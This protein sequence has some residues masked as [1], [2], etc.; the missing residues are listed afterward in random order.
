MTDILPWTDSHRMVEAWSEQRLP[1]EPKGNMLD[2]R[3]RLR[4]ELRTLP[5]DGGPALIAEY[6][7]E[8]REVCDVENVLFYNVGLRPFS[9][10]GV[11]QLA[12]S[13]VQGPPRQ[14]AGC[15]GARHYVSYRRA[16]A[17]STPDWGE[18]AATFTSA[19]LKAG[20]LGKPWSAWYAL[21]RGHTHVAHMIDDK[22]GFR[23]RVV[24][25]CPHPDSTSLFS[26]LKGL[27]DGVIAALQPST[28]PKNEP[29][30]VL[31]SHLGIV[32]HD[33][34]DLLLSPAGIA[35]QTPTEILRPFGPGRIQINPADHLLTSAVVTLSASPDD[36]AHI[37]GSLF[38]T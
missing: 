15:E 22:R 18:P 16:A 19:P 26:I 20:V 37:V 6:R 10:L 38:R 23:L 14:R 33:A 4:A 25:T 32:P 11:R 24:V 3:N 21:K 34:R 13:R 9:R 35:M 28:P 7:S 30:A 5:P 12:F 31:A 27:L 36:Q 29:L 17:V 1:F 8:I 2:F